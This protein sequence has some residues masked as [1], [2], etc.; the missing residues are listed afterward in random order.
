M[1]R[2]RAGGGEFF[3]AMKALGY[4]EGRDVV[5]EERYWRGREL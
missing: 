2:A 1:E 4:V 3:A 5:Y